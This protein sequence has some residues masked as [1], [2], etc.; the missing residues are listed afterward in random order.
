MDR[1][2]ARRALQQG[3]ER[4]EMR[5]DPRFRL[6]LAAVGVT[7]TTAH[8]T[9]GPDRLVA[10]YGPWVCETTLDNVRDVA[11]TGP[12]RWFRA[13]GPRLSLSDRGLTFGTTPERGACLSLREPVP[14]LDP[15]GLLRHPALT[16]T[17]AEPERFAAAVSRRRG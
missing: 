6:P 15:L 7:P 14:G 9:L 2:T 11:V 17:V 4:F 16:F 1:D 10:R 3:T 5:F 12:Y 8:V 13:V